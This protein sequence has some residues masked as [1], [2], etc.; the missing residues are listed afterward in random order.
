[1]KEIIP[2][3]KSTPSFPFIKVGMYNGYLAIPCELC[4]YINDT[5]SLPQPHGGITFEVVDFVEETVDLEGAIDVFGDKL[6]NIPNL[7]QLYNIRVR[8]LS[9]WGH[10]REMEFG[11]CF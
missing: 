5:E 4:P 3:L 6:K 8:Y 10:S 1:M 9:L 2:F 11:D 7:K